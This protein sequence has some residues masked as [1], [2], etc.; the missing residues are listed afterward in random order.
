MITN[1]VA[2]FITSKTLYIC[3]I[4]SNLPSEEPALDNLFLPDGAALGIF[5]LPDG[6]AETAA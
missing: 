6:A 2:L 1:L 3:S 5:F 4:S